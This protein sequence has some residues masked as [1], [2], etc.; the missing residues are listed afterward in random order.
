MGLAN[1]WRRRLTTYGF[2]VHSPFAYKFIKCVLREKYHF[3][4]FTDEVRSR[5]ERCLFRVANY[6]RPERVMILGP[7]TARAREII[8]MAC[9]RAKIVNSDADFTYTSGPI[10][11][12]FKTLYCTHPAEVDDAMTFS[13]GQT[14]IAVRRP[15][16]PAQSFRLYF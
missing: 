13:N 3:Y 6:F 10:P 9:P 5:E 1:W 11:S 7:D 8:G 2:G 4:C 12:H 16:L 15:G 14:L